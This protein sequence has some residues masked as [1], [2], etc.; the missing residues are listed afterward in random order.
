MCRKPWDLAFTAEP[1]GVSAL[2]RIMRFHLGLWGLHDISDQAQLCVSELVSNVINHVGTGTPVTLM[3]SMRDTRVRIE[4]HDPDT[5]D[6]PT[7]LEA[8]RD[9]E[10]GRGMA[11]V[12]AVSDRWGVQ[13]LADRKVT[14][15][16]LSTA[17]PSA[18]GHVGG[19]RVN[20]VEGLLRECRGARPH[21]W[22]AGDGAVDVGG[23]AAIEVMVDV[24]HWL[25]AHG[26]DADE[27]LD[28]VQDRFESETE[29]IDTVG[30]R[31]DGGGTGHRRS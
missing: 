9:A 20:R 25:R 22:P 12:G 13:L 17:L 26:R 28:R 14:W 15:C 27:A 1:E 16:E 23:E 2:R 24:L 21:Q 19:T 10:F 29:D 8:T 5:R 6:L 18:E 7:L 11:L 30:S 4:I 3:V 31:W